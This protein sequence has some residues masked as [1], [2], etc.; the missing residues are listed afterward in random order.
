[1]ICLMKGFDLFSMARAAC[2]VSGIVIGI[3]VGRRRG[4]ISLRGCDYGWGWA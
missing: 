1:M 4:F 3:V 2:L